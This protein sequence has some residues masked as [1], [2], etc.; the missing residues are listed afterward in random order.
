MCSLGEYAG[1][2]QAQTPERQRLYSRACGI[3]HGGPLAQSSTLK[4]R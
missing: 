1:L 3:E 2:G 4:V